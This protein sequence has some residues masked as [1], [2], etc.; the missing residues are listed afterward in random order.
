M[1]LE[2]P[3][4]LETALGAKARH[5]GVSPE[6]YA[7]EVLERE[8]QAPSELTGQ[9]AEFAALAARLPHYARGVS[10]SEEQAQAWLDD[11]RADRDTATWG[12]TFGAAQ[13]P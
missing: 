3:T 12:A 11:A 8:A 6:H 4:P 7:I 5:Q 2:I 10:F 1:T 9:W 13:T